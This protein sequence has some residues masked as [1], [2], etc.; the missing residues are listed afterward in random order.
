MAA[1]S[2]AATARLESAKAAT[3]VV[4]ALNGWSFA[5][6]AS[7]IPAVRDGL[8]LTPQDLGLLLLVGSAGAILGLPLAGWVAHRIGAARTVLLGA[9]L[10]LSA[11]AAIGL[12]VGVLESVPLTTGVL[13]VLCF[14]MGQW[15]VAMNL[16]GADVEHRLGR[17]IMPRYHAA[18]SL[19]T[20]GS[21]LAGAA[22]AWAGVPVVAH[23]GVSAVLIGVAVVVAVRAFLPMQDHAGGHPDPAAPAAP[24]AASRDRQRSAW[25][26]PR[27]LLIGVVTLVT[28]FTEGTAND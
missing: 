1:P 13:V 4:F 10:D 14:G 3:S 11:L 15:D 19:G 21:A 22:L 7:R 9:A 2:A 23:F 27:T 6:W 5:T 24:A 26:E 12:T 18:F 16:Q 8:S 25:R 28:A 17:T 20:V